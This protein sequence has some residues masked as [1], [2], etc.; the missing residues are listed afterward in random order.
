MPNRGAAMLCVILGQSEFPFSASYA[1]LGWQ[2]LSVAA[3]ELSAFT[4][5]TVIVPMFVGWLIKEQLVGS[6]TSG[7]VK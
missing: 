5:L 1:S 3:A 2:P 7:S 6:L 4:S